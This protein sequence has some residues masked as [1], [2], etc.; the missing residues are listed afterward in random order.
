MRIIEVYVKYNK[1]ISTHQKLTEIYQYK[2][3]NWKRLSYNK[4]ILKYMFNPDIEWNDLLLKSITK[5]NV[6]IFNFL[7]YS[8]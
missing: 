1:T 7:T 4:N 2:D 6:I 5:C 3:W 8:Y